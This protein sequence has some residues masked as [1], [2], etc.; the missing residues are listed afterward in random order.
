MASVVPKSMA[1]KSNYYNTRGYFH[2]KEEDGSVGLGEESVFSTLAKVEVEPAKSNANYVHLR[3]S[4]F[5]RYWQRK[6]D[7]SWFIAAE[8]NQPEEDTTNPSCTLFEPIKVPDDDPAG[9]GFFYLI[10]VQ[11]GGRLLIDNDTFVFYV[12]FN[13]KSY[14]G[15]LKAADMD[16]L[17]KLPPLVAFKGLTGFVKGFRVDVRNF[18]QVSSYDRNEAFSRHQVRLMP[19]G[20]VR[21]LCEGWGLWWR[22]GADDWIMGDATDENAAG[23]LFWPLKIDGAT[24]ALQNQ[25][26]GN[27]CRRLVVPG[28]V[29]TD[30]LSA[31]ESAP[32]RQAGLQVEELVAE[33]K[34]SNVKFLMEYARVFDLEPYTAWKSEIPNDTDQDANMAVVITYE[35]SRSYSFGRSYTFPAGVPT[36]I[37]ADLP[38]VGLGAAIA[39][40]DYRISAPLQW[41]AANTMTSTVQATGF[42]PVP[43]RHKAEVQYLGTRATCSIPFTYT[44]SDK[45]SAPSGATSE[46]LQID[47]IYTAVSCFQFNFNIINFKDL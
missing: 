37:E 38:F 46:T 16:A 21:L 5:N 28:S 32:S 30:S 15:Y 47:G 9:A 13:P 34:I 29:F 17:V 6:S 40:S 2:F 41:N 20:H 8:S 12:E 4:H 26:N 27:F 14:Q 44:Q 25:S 23:T 3:F 43:A 11:S 39:P 1:V 19:D 31:S 36:T 42:I 45:S 24:I 18:L 35:D 33:R 10:H 22:L 7:G